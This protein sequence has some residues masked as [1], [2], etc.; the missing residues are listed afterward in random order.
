MQL[1]DAYGELQ[2]LL[3]ETANLTDFLQQVTQIAAAA[4]GTDAC[5]I[6]LDHDGEPV[7]VASSDHLANHVDEIQYSRGEGPCLF[8]MSTGST[9][10]IRDLAEEERWPDY[11]PRA[12]AAGIRSSL[13]L[14]LTMGEETV[15]ALNLYASKP[16]SFGDDQQNLAETFARQAVT[17]MTIARRQ[18]DRISLEDQLRQ[19]LESRAVIDQA[20]G[21]IMGQRRCTSREAFAIL[22]E[23][24]QQLN[25]KLAA[26]AAGVIE[27][28][29]GRPYTPPTPFTERRQQRRD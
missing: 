8:S 1:A 3:L 12:I 16:D 17:A 29:T 19:A 6:T 22:R 7:T 13:S 21:I 9:V 15:G 4:V 28:A 24:S 27:T 2:R 25:R 23:T 20:C 18:A 5:G 14:P 26:V 11:A 10:L